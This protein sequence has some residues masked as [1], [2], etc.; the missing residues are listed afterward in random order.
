MCATVALVAIMVQQ[1]AQP[2]VVTMTAAMAAGRAMTLGTQT[3]VPT[4]M[5][6]ILLDDLHLRRLRRLH[7]QRLQLGVVRVRDRLTPAVI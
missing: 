7:Q 5:C 4:T 2:I 3:L 6:R 1:P